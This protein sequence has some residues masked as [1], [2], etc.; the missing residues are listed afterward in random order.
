MIKKV[1]FQL[2][3]EKFIERSGPRKAQTNRLRRREK[4]A[5]GANV[6]PIPSVPERAPAKAATVL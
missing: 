4:Y 3:V 2:D 5:F 6:F 1:F